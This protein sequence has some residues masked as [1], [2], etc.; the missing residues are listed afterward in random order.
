VCSSDLRKTGQRFLTV[1]ADEADGALDPEARMKY[2]AMIERAHIEAGR[3]HTVIVTHSTEIQDF[4]A[5]K[6]IMGKKI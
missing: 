4:I 1:F 6:I 2:I 5:Q 3:T